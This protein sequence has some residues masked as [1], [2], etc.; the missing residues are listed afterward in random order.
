MRY[1]LTAGLL[2]LTLLLGSTSA[3]RADGFGFNFSYHASGSFGF[4][5]GGCGSGGGCWPCPY[6]HCAYAPYFEYGWP[7]SVP[8][9]PGS[10]PGYGFAPP[11]VQP[12][13][14]YS[15]PTPPP[16]YAPYYWSPR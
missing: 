15:I 1:F 7:T 6:D 4:N 11:Y 12:P 3:A 9:Y 14:P 10:A 5:I 8:V 13:S 2:S 16:A